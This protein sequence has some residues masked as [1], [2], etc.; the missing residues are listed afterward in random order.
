M[1]NRTPTK[2]LKPFLFENMAFRPRDGSH[3]I[4]DEVLC[5][6]M[7]YSC[8]Q[9]SDTDPDR[10]QSILGH[11]F[12]QNQIK[13]HSDFEGLKSKWDFYHVSVPNFVRALN[14]QRYAIVSKISFRRVKFAWWVKS[15]APSGDTIYIYTN[16]GFGLRKIRKWLV[17]TIS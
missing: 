11:A 5:Y 6:F 7:L 4:C 1:K 12:Q 16:T 2:Q 13:I 9:N 10:K 14:P 15:S 17:F 8:V 3:W